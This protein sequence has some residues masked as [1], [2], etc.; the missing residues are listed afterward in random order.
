MT[1]KRSL[2]EQHV[3]EQT[4]F[5]SEDSEQWLAFVCL[6]EIYPSLTYWSYD[7][8]YCHALADYSVNL[9]WLKD[10]IIDWSTKEVLHKTDKM[11]WDSSRAEICKVWLRVNGETYKTKR[12]WLGFK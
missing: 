8:Y 12:E 4:L 6:K 3:L 11:F 1:D 5:P 2:L 7:G 10:E 9:V